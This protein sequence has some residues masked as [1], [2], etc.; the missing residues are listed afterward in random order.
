MTLPAIGVYYPSGCFPIKIPEYN[1]INK[2][3]LF[4]ELWREYENG[5]DCNL[6]VEEIALLRDSTHDFK[7]SSTEEELV[8]KYFGLPEE[9]GRTDIVEKTNSEI[10]SYIKVNSQITV[11]Q[12]KLGL[13]LKNMGFKQTSKKINGTTARLYQVIELQRSVANEVAKDAF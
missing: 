4:Y 6:S 10:L 7:Q 11:S 8:L 1:K 3:Y 5:F 12:T 2:D 9:L 13:V